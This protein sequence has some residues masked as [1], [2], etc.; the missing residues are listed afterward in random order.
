MREDYQDYP[1][2]DWED[3][4]SA[5]KAAACILDEERLILLMPRELDLTVD[6]EE[7]GC[8]LEEDDGMLYGCDPGEALE[9]LAEATGIESLIEVGEAAAEVGVVLDIDL[10]GRRLIFRAL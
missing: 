8:D 7:C 10:E 2:L 9:I 3:D 4:Y 1:L 6:S 5:A